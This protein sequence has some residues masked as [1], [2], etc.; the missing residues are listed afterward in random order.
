MSVTS[1]PSDPQYV[2]KSLWQYRALILQMIRREVVGRYRGSLLGILWSFFNPILMLAVYTFVFSVVFQARW[3]EGTG[4]KTEF[5]IIL[6]AG[7]IVYSLFAECLNR[8]PGLILSNVN[9][10]KKVVFPLE[11]L[12]W[13]ALGASLF[14]T[15][16]SIGV[17]LIFYVLVNLDFNWTA[18]FLPLVL[19]PLAIL[20]MGLSWFLASIGVYLR[21]VGQTIGIVTTVMLF[22][23][24]IFYPVAALPEEYRLLLELNPLSFIIEQAR[25]VLVW[26]KPPDWMGLSVYLVCAIMV[27]WLGLSWFQKTR[28]GFADVL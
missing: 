6:F 28:R 22:L 12:P 20:T 27:A 1:F 21:D 17:L 2:F 16:I 10:V 25:D 11:I 18:I 5:A 4:S 3:G 26:G 23:S 15:A 13:V 7:L 24:P 14:H 9:F 19:L 8:A